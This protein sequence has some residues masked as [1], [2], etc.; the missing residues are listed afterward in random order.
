[1]NVEK[2][3]PLSLGEEL[4]IRFV[5]VV[6]GLNSWLGLWMLFNLPQSYAVIGG[7][8]GYIACHIIAG[9]CVSSPATQRLGEGREQY[10][11]RRIGELQ[12]VLAELE[13][14]KGYRS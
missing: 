10:L 1:M 3:L 13:Q 11:R 7:F 9:A 8:A 14:K 12:E 2:S 6:I 4:L 5:S